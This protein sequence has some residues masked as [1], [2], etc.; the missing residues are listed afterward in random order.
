MQSDPAAPDR[1]FDLDWLRII[2][3]GLLI[4]YHVGMFYVP[5]DWHVKS[6]HIFDDLRPVMLLTNPWRLSLLFIIS[7]VATR[8]MADKIAPGRLLRTRSARLLLPL[9]FGMLVV[10]PP[11]TWCEIVEKLGYAGSWLDFYGKYLGFYEG[12]RPDGR[13]L[14]VPTWNHLWFVAYLWLYTMLV[15]MAQPLLR[16]VRQVWLERLLQWRLAGAIMLVIPCLLLAALRLLLRPLFGETHALFDDW[17]LHAIYFPLFLF[18]FM[19]A[20][21]TAAWT[22]IARLRAVALICALL[23]WLALVAVMLLY[24]H[25]TDVPAILSLGVKVGWA[26]QQWCGC[27]ALLGYAQRWLNRDSTWRRYMT[28]AV[29]P[30]YIVHQTVIVVIGHQLSP[31]Q[32]PAWLEAIT[33]IG[34]TAAACLGTFE[35]ARR[36]AWLRPLFGLKPQAT[37]SHVP[38]FRKMDRLDAT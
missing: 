4:L 8:F 16:S 7:G 10:V 21:C 25:G 13:K 30:F 29:F 20:P 23:A 34:I 38:R 18:G 9:M 6:S 26:T 24:P 32:L 28:D 37:A 33:I 5:W 17:Y 12:W 31:L 3:F 35:I 19:A 15:L 1:R 36:V 27:I 11:Q 22:L 14:L 2:V